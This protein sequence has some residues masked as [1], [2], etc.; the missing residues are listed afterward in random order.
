MTCYSESVCMTSR[1]LEG[2][3]GRNYGIRS[4][5]GCPG[6]LRSCWLLYD[7]RQTAAARTSV[8]ACIRVCRTKA[9]GWRADGAAL[10]TAQQRPLHWHS[11][12]MQASIGGI[13]PAACAWGRLCSKLVPAAAC[14]AAVTTQHRLGRPQTP[15]FDALH[16]PQPAAAVCGAEC[17]C[18]P[19]SCTA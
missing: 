6:F 7:A 3:V 19:G 18:S 14:A 4:L 12:A 13:T 1:L 5:W 16:R 17:K 9:T 11:T 2:D 10:F 8:A 15:T